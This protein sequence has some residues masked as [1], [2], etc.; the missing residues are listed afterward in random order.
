MRKYVWLGLLRQYWLVIAEV[1]W[2]LEST[3]YGLGKGLEGMARQER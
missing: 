2:V 1:A 3:A